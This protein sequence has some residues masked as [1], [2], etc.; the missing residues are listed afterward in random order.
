IKKILDSGADPNLADKF[1]CTAL[2]WMLR[3]FWRPKSRSAQRPS[4]THEQLRSPIYTF[5]L[6]EMDV[7]KSPFTHGG[8]VKSRNFPCGLPLAAAVRRGF[9]EGTKVLMVDI[10]HCD[11]LRQTPL[12]IAVERNLVEVAKLLIDAG[13]D[14]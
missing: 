2:H 1:G 6:L 12:T 3:L 14:I 10:D 9:V 13:A 11:D 8:N 5:E 4:S 7:N